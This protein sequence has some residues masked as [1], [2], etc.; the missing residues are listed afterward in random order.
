VIVPEYLY[1]LAAVYFFIFLIREII[2]YRGILFLKYLLTP[3]ITACAVFIVLISIGFYGIDRYN[4]LIFS[5]L[6]AALAADT[7]LML[8]ET[9][10]LK[11]GIIF[12]MMSHLLY[13]AAFCSELTFKPWNVILLLFICLVNFFFIRIMKRHA[14][15]MLIPVI[16]YVLMID[17]MGYLAL[18][19]LNNGAGRYEIVLASAAVLF[20]ISDLI[21]SVNAFVKKI[22]HS[23]VYTWLFYAPAQFLFAVSAIFIHHV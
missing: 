15:R 2:A 12:F 11:N 4:F 13:I 7:L 19:K 22:P 9:S 23:T 8:E 17:T 16:L 20:W 5:S 18:T 6:L 21:L 14:G 1:H 10:Y 3:M